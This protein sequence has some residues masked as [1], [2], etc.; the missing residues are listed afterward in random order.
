MSEPLRVLHAIRSDGFAGVEQFV[1]RLALAQ[2]AV[3]HEVAVV[4]GDPERMRPALAAAGVDHVP[5][6]RTAEVVRAV[7]RRAAATDVVNTHM[8]AADVAGVVALGGGRRP[9][10]VSTRHFAQPRGRVGPV[11][12]DALVRHRIDA[13]L[14]IS[15]AVAGAV[16]HPTTVVHTGVESR[17]LGDG[18]PRDR[19]VLV[20]Q[21]LEP[22]KHTHVAVRAF[23]ASRLADDGWTLEIAGDGSERDAVRALAHD[24]GLDGLVR[25]SGFRSDLAAVMDRS[26]ILVAPCPVE[27]LG[28]TVL[29]AMAGG[30]P[31]VAAAAGGHVE[32]LE[33]LDERTLFPPDD[34]DDAARRLRELAHDEPGRADLG[35][36]ARA[37]QQRDFSLHA[38]VEGTDAV[39][40]EVL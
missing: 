2:S 17:P 33:G 7:R 21:R 10:L 13:E 12:I 35:T 3:G 6:A 5:A 15:S 4:G 1:L 37:R 16:G 36:A 39:Y 19:T 18:R 9:A 20:A 32:L 11:P 34:V 25:F 30:L 31:V 40:R 22:E 27:G 23:A 38:Q 24:L 26:G 14:S 8:S 29:E 28:L